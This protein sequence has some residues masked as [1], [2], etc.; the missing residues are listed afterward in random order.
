MGDILDR[1][2]RDMNKKILGTILLLVFSGCSSS[3]IVKSDPLQADVYVRDPKT[4]DKKPLGKTPL[5]MKIPDVK[6]AVGEELLSGEFFTVVVEK[7]GYQTESYSI[8][9]TRFGT[10]V[11]MLDVKMKQGNV[12]K[13][14]H[15]AKDILD[16]L[17]LA[18][19]YAL[20]KEFER[21]QIEV[22]KVLA[23]FPNFAKAMSMRASIYYVQKN[24][25][26]S[27]KW[28]TEA[29]KVDPQNDNAVEM[30]AKI[31]RIQ[32]GERIPASAA[33]VSAGGKKP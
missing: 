13:E 21:A 20:A 26:E 23:T 31:Q 12:I 8:P 3:F 4:G 24:F 15:M 17:F 19:R 16:H 33:P 18:Q 25:P 27:L 30:V 28:Y 7:S 2:S 1:D 32:G 11:T 14:E 22:D 9:A 5:E 6:A 10:L 29:L